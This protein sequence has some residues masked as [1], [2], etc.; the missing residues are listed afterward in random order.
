MQRIKFSV[1]MAVY[2]RDNAS[3]FRKALESVY[4]NTVRPDEFVLVVDGPLGIDLLR[5]ISDFEDVAGFHVFWLEQNVGL[6]RALNYGLQKVSHEV[7]FRADADDINLEHRFSLQLSE[8]T[9][10]ADVV[11]GAILEID[12]ESRP[13][14]IRKLPLEHVEIADFAKMRCPMNHMTVAYRKSCVLDAGGY[15]LIHMKEDYA[16]W[17]ALLSAGARFKNTPI[18]LV[19]ATAGRNM[20]SRRGGWRYVRSEIV[21][22]RHL[23][24]CGIQT[25]S[26]ALVVGFLRSLVFVAPNRIRGFIYEKF[27]R[28]KFEAHNQ[29]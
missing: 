15:P 17:A 1:L 25:A 16:L 24:Q 3:I 14:A 4:R 5:V 27:L 26:R 12:E 6:A 18:V 20:Y 10:G 29:L 8:F 21:L 9:R 2:A 22:Q 13:I 28:H 23:V 7:I 11:G 19:H